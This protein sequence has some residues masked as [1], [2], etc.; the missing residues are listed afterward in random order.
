[1]DLH[2]SYYFIYTQTKLKFVATE[3]YITKQY[4][5]IISIPLVKSR[6]SAYDSFI[7]AK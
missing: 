7:T 5:T 3:K 1:M 2:K 6:G 4:K